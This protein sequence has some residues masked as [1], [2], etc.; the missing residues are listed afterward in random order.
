[1]DVPHSQSINRHWFLSKPS[2]MLEQQVLLK[3]EGQ[4]CGSVVLQRYLHLTCH[5]L[6]ATKNMGG[7]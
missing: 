6:N 2:A 1:M 7:I 5:V 4:K 3:L